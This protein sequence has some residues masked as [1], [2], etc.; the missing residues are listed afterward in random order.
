MEDGVER[1]EEVLTSIAQQIEGDLTPEQ[2]ELIESELEQYKEKPEV[3]NW[4]FQMPPSGPSGISDPKVILPESLTPDQVDRLKGIDTSEYEE[5]QEEEIIQGVRSLTPEQVDAIEA[6]LEPDMS[7]EFDVEIGGSLGPGELTAGNVGWKKSLGSRW[8]E[9]DRHGWLSNAFWGMTVL[10]QGVARQVVNILENLDLLDKYEAKELL[11]RQEVHGSDIVNWYWRNPSD[12]GETV[13]RFITGLAADIFLDPVS[14][15][16]IA[17]LLTAAGKTA[18]VGKTVVTGLDKMSAAQ[19]G[20]YRGAEKISKI[21]DVENGKLLDVANVSK[22]NPEE[23]VLQNEQALAKYADGKMGFTELEKSLNVSPA[24]K[25]QILKAR[26]ESIQAGGLKRVGQEF[27]SGERQWKIGFNIP[28]TRRIW[29]EVPLSPMWLSK[30][31]GNAI[32]KLGEAFDLTGKAIRST[33]AGELVSRVWNNSWTKTGK[34]VFDEQ[35]NKWHGS[36]GFTKKM[37]GEWEHS[38]RKVFDEYKKTMPQEDYDQ[39]VKD[40]VDEMEWG[41]DASPVEIMLR[42]K[43]EPYTITDVTRPFTEY[44]LHGVTAEG[45]QIMTKMVDSAGDSM[46]EII[47]KTADIASMYDLDLDEIIEITDAYRAGKFGGKR[48]KEYLETPEHMKLITSSKDEARSARLARAP[49]LMSL[50]EQMRQQNREMIEAYKSRGVPME[51]LNPFGPGWVNSYAAHVVTNDWIKSRKG[52]AGAGQEIEDGMRFL[53]KNVGKYDKSSAGRGYRGSINEANEKTLEEHGVKI[54]VDD[55]IELH[56]RRMR[57]MQNVIDNYDL[58]NAASAHAIVGDLPPNT[59]GYVKFDPRHFRDFYMKDGV[60]NIKNIGPQEV[61]KPFLPDFFKQRKN[62]WIPADVYDRLLFTANNQRHFPVAAKMLDYVDMYTKL[63]RNNA[64]FG[65]GYIGLN[66]FSNLTTYAS[67]MGADA[68]PGLVKAT[69]MMTTKSKNI[70]IDVNDGFG[71]MARKNGEELWNMAFEDNV[72]Q[73][74]FMGELKFDDLAEHVASNR[75]ARKGWKKARTVADHAFLWSLSRQ[76]A[77]FMDDIPK[78]AVYLDRLSKGFTREAAA[79][80]AERYFYNYNNVSRYQNVVRKIVPFSTFPMK[81]AEMIAGEIKRGRIGSLTIPHKVQ[82]ALEGSFVADKD[83]RDYLNDKLPIWRDWAMDPIH[84]MMM[85]G[86]NEVLIEMPWAAAT[87]SMIMNPD[88]SL[89]PVTQMLM[90]AAS[91][92]MRDDFLERAGAEGYGEEFK[93]E[94][95]KQVELLIPSYLKDALSLM[96][97]NDPVGFNFGGY[98]ADR[99]TEITPGEKDFKENTPIAQRFDNAADFGRYLDKELGSG[100]LYNI[101]FPSKSDDISVGAREAQGARGNFIRKKFRQFT[102][103]LGS[104]TKFDANYLLYRTAIDRRIRKLKADMEQEQR[105]AGNLFDRKLLTSDEALKKMVED[106]NPLAIEIQAL[107]Y[108]MDADD[109]YYNWFSQV[110]KDYP[111]LNP[112]DVIF[113]TDKYN[114]SYDYKPSQETIMQMDYDYNREEAEKLFEEMRAQEEQ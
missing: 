64:L 13:A 81:T 7:S 25:E 102:F 105:K 100:W 80:A 49:Q 106:G 101:M 27:M 22:K 99:Y 34:Y 5:D 72:L 48:G 62:I 71:N 107:D 88:Q 92:D 78:L 44:T 59:Y 52:I 110:E 82:A 38:A 61:W 97:I 32:H 36:K 14:Y 40:F 3:S 47:E 74:G 112:V 65:F 93:R 113:G 17:G 54:F 89:H 6:N 63:W 83:T 90:M 67:M 4:G 111:E 20:F 98:F 42:H 21:L 75:E 16:P 51:E 109:E 9:T 2:V 56:A 84:G 66:A 29:A 108:K 1:S 31:S 91:R 60:R 12:K 30:L 10:E 28:F 55:P 70:A 43:K 8:D 104:M 18:K 77:Q 58:M 41:L 53:Q 103:G 26:R 33:E 86:M 68:L 46:D 87:L 50:L 73:S 94:L 11:S 35:L 24:G 69:K 57:E 79:E 114:F 95:G 85:P 39:L 19:R 37:I 23:L 76:S 15:I 96:E 45:A